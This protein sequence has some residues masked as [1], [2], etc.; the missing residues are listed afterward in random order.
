M[1]YAYDNSIVKDLLRSFNPDNVPDPVVKV[2]DPEGVPMLAAQ[3]QNDE[4]KLPIV[5]VY[6]DPDTP[7]DW[8]RYNFTRAKKGVP[9]VFDND[10]NNIYYEKVVPVKLTYKL[11]VLTHSTADMDELV[12]E[13]L[14]KY[15]DQYFLTLT[16]PYESKRRIRFG[17]VVDPDGSIERTSGSFQ[18][19]QNGQLHQTIIP[20]K[21]EGAV[22]ITYTPQQLRNTDYEVTAK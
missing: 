22:L 13:L 1:L 17:L 15:S 7:I 20:L 3:I 16:V 14:F 18:Y 8:E 12:R 19:L 6:R 2:I 9:C 11:T 10:K 5:S 21:V 4:I